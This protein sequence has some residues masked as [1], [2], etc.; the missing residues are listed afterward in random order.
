MDHDSIY[1]FSYGSESSTIGRSF[2][3]LSIMCAENGTCDT[4]TDNDNEFQSLF[5]ASCLHSNSPLKKMKA[6]WVE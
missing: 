2:W 3:W 6:A 5:G 4:D 1:E